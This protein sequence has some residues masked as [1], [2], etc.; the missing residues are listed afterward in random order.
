MTARA[1]FDP[2]SRPSDASTRRIKMTMEVN[3]HDRTIVVEPRTTLLEALRERCHLT[4]TVGSCHQGNCGACTVLVDRE[5]VRS[6]IVFAV[7]AHGTMVQTVEGLAHEGELHPLQRAFCREHAIQC[8]YCT[9]GFLMLAYGALHRD[10]DMDATAVSALV[11]ANVCR[12]VAY[13]PI[14]RAIMAAQGE[15]Q[16]AD[17]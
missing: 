10:I 12:C 7:Q 9:P 6:C 13:T 8:G 17:E 15:M 11:C 5:P 3:G 16:A 4:G 14:V 2:G 1:T